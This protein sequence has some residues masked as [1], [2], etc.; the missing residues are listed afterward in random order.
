M[1]EEWLGRGPSSA[2]IG[3]RIYQVEGVDNYRIEGP[4]NDVVVAE[5]QLPVLESV[6]VEELR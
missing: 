6:S 4:A 2:Q 5:N 3:Q 1:T